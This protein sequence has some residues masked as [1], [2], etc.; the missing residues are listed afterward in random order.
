MFESIHHVHIVGIGGIG[1]SAIAK[2]LVHKG[3]SVS[4]SD[5]M[6]SSITQELEQRGVKIFSGHAL[7]HISE[8]TDLLLYS[9]AVLETNPEPQMAKERD[10]PQMSY[11]EV[12]GELSKEYSTIAVCGTNGKSTTTAMLGLILEAAGYDP[13]VIVGSKVAS[14]PDGNLR[15]GKG[16]FLVVEACEHQA[17]F[18]HM[19]P[20]MIVVTNIEEDHLDY[21][22]DINH[23]RETFQA[24]VDKRKGKGLVVWNADDPQSQKLVLDR[25]I[26]YGHEE[27]DYHFYD[28][29]TSAGKQ[30]A[31]IQSTVDGREQS[32]EKLELRVPGVY[33]LM[34]A[35]AAQTAAM[36]LGVPLEII[37]KTLEIFPGIWRR[38]ERIGMW[39]GAE[40]ISD[41]GHHPTAITQTREGI[42]E[43]FPGKRLVHV[44]QP[45]QHAR[46]KMLFNEFV[47][48]LVGSDIL[49]LSEIYYVP[50]RTD[51]QDISSGDL[52]DAIKKRSPHQVIHYAK[53]TESAEMLLRELVREEDI[54]LIQGAGDID[55]VARKLV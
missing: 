13:T 32:L 26:S 17:H 23:I 24:F 27:G 37:Q 1:I 19:H 30:W 52:M 38:F 25:G 51:A 7:E 18:L 11:P 21:Y 3:I 15:L 54:V 35:L 8:K 22:R 55:K 42:R 44:F 31:E 46:T 53:D 39:H 6:S 29:E 43:F 12:L 28:R 40:I 50:G 10:I 33:N 34:N 9:P 45:H 5:M 47:E 48:S 36:E 2:L 16:R 49:I 20:E 41:Y 4:G 14:F